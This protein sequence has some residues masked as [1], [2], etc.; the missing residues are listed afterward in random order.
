MQCARY[1]K[2]SCELS[3]AADALHPHYYEGSEYAEWV[4][5]LPAGAGCVVAADELLLSNA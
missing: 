1:V 2:D 3:E 4:S 5:R